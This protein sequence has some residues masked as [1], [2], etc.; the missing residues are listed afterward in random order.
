MMQHRLLYLIL[1]IILLWILAFNTDTD[2]GRSFFSAL[3][4]LSTGGLILSYVWSRL[5]LGSVEIQRFTRSGHSQ[6]GQRVDEL[7]ELTNHARTPKLWLELTDFSTLP[8]HDSSRIISNLMRGSR[9]RWQ[10]R[11]Q[12]TVRGRYRLGPLR[13]RS[14]DP[15]GL[16]VQEQHLA[17]QTPIVVYPYTIELPH[18]AP[19]ISDLAGDERIRL[20]TQIITTNASSVRDYAPGD[21]QNRIHWLSTART[22]HLMTK[23]FELEPSA[24]VWVFF[25]LHQDPAIVLPQPQPADVWDSFPW[26]TRRHAPRIREVEL[27]PSTTEYV[28]TVAASV[29]RHFLQRNR[30]V[31]L[32][33]YGQTRVYL[34]VDRG[35]RQLLR[36]LETLAVLEAEG[37]VPMANFLLNEG[38]HLNRSETLIVVTA[39]PDPAWVHALR[40][41]RARGTRSLAIVIDSHTFDPTVDL[42]PVWREL[43]ATAIPYYRVA[44]DQKLDQALAGEATIG[45]HPLRRYPMGP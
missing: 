3:A 38:M 17:T 32:A 33:A 42:Q 22:G 18:F 21:S 40:E 44:K 2:T 43:Q 26:R 36:I 11:T 45:H 14:S 24:H 25:D 13:L 6:I 35:E 9:R 7:F 29:L 39:D 23:E 4:Y 1:A 15:L 37:T 20:R 28:I 19:V 10:V 5:S 12:C 31:G 34:P 8:G 41:L 30:G 27:P 16:F